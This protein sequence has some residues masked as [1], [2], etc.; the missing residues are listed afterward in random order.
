MVIHLSFHP[1]FHVFLYM[2][3][4]LPI[5]YLIFS[6]IYLQ[7]RVPIRTVEQ[8]LLVMVASAIV[9]QRFVHLLQLMYA[10]L[11][12]ANVELLRYVLKV[13]LWIN[14]V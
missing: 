14:N 11:E 3:D 6:H 8:V 5:S 9:V 7:T 13:T 12:L 1:I 2:I 10:M 4:S